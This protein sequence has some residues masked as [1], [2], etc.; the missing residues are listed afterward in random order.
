MS[1][2]DL[3]YAAVLAA[4]VSGLIPCLADPRR[5]YVG[6]ATFALLGVAGALA[7]AAGAWALIADLALT[8]RLALGL[9]WLKWHVRLDALGGFFTLVVG[10]LVLAVSVYGPSYMREFERGPQPLVVLH[11]FTGLFV[12]GMLLVLLADDAFSFMVAWELMSVSSY[13]LVTFQHQNAANRRAG[14][15]Y[16]LMAH[17]GALGILLGFGVLAG[18]GGSFTFE[19]MREADL[20]ST[21]ASIAFALALFGFG[22]KAGMVPVHAWLP[23]AHPVA[24][25]H[26]SALMSGVMLKVAIYGFVRFTFDLV[27]EIQW[28]WGVTVLVIGAAS[29]LLGVLY[30]L[31]QHDIKRLLAYSSVEN[32]GIILIALGLSMIFLGTGHPNLGAIGLVAA[33]YHALNHAMFKGLLFLGAGAVLFRAHERDLEHLGGLIHRMPA[34]AALFLVGSIAIAGLPPLNGFVS[35]WLT[36]QTA[37]QAG[38]L[39]SGVL[40]S[41]LPIA[42]AVLALTAAL[43]AAAFV[44]VY[45]V[46][47]LGKA[48]SRHAARA[49]EVPRGMLV[50]MGLLAALCVLLGVLPTA[51]ISAMDPI[52]QMLVGRGLPSATAQGWLW[53]TPVSPQV[54]SY[55]APLV[56]VAIGI[57]YL[58]GRLVARREPKPRRTHAWDCGFGALNSRMQYTSAA[59]AMPIRRVFGPVWK[60]SEQVETTRPAN[61]PTSVAT[62]RHQLHIEDWSWGFAYEPIGR[63]VLNAARRVGRIQTGSIRAYLVYSFLTLLLL[64]WIVTW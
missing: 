52:P 41:V 9:P 1:A 19:A 8:D 11:L 29:A 18:F 5:R 62:L 40:R 6:G 34:T 3:A 27:G 13:F 14:F 43:G 17:V 50:S 61:A 64:L 57:T 23:E 48:R 2:L 60:V 47:F 12:A 56:L 49:R 25:S 58:L 32:V 22:M 28:Q 30:A 15:L 59:F 35:E 39:E 44:K 26:I 36:F 63:L 20:S 16:L 45:G 53:L 38:A 7:V 4:I 21:W 46:A 31:M 55:S 33:L 10:L 42:A 37:L 24:P 51:V 54:A